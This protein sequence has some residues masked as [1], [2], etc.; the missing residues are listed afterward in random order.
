MVTKTEQALRLKQINPGHANGTHQLETDPD[1]FR[2]GWRTV[3]ETLPNGAIGY[4]EPALKPSR[5][6]QPPAR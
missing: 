2:Y 5:L 1:P 3:A 4:R 6:S